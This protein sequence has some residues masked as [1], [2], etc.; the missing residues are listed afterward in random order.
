[1]RLQLVQVVKEEEPELKKLKK[2]YGENVYN[3]VA[4]ALLEISQY[5]PSGRYPVATPWNHETS[6]KATL[7]DVI[8]HLGAEATRHKIA[9]A[10]SAKK[11]QGLEEQLKELTAAL[12][13][14]H[15]SKP[16]TTRGR[17]KRTL[18]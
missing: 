16:T 4:T 17:G 3:S 6:E 5:N 10:A 12:G 15:S 2:Q 1:M 8:N 11:C 7:A 18:R 13:E 14:E 9:A